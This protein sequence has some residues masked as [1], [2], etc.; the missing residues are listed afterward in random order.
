[1]SQINNDATPFQ[2]FDLALSNGHTALATQ[3]RV[4]NN[5][6]KAF[7]SEG[8]IVLIMGINLVQSQFWI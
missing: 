3:Q 8:F 2:A 4:Y 7:I 1:M 6:N 5:S